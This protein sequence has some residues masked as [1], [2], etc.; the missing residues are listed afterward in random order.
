M[1]EA[2]D[3]PPGYTL[4]VP[5]GQYVQDELPGPLYV[6]EGH[7]VQA[8]AVVAERFIDAVPAAQGKQLPAADPEY[9]M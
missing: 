5:E 7:D 6:P 8:S 1:H 9:G 3:E 2:D 4:K